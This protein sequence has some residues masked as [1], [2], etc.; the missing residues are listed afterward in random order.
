MRSTEHHA[1]EWSERALG[2]YTLLRHFRKELETDT[3]S[4]TLPQ[5]TVQGHGP[6]LSDAE[7]SSA[8]IPS[9]S[10]QDI[11]EFR[12]KPFQQNPLEVMPGMT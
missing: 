11:S 5:G 9:G 1:A 10:L 12:S 7:N 6:E 3:K 8:S 2:I 4:A